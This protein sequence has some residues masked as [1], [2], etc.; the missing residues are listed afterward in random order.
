MYAAYLIE[1][2]CATH[3]Y[4]QGMGNDERTIARSLEV[5][6]FMKDGVYSDEIPLNGCILREVL[7][8]R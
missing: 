1:Q 4:P 2:P 5:F 3:P 6:K 7:T 8:G